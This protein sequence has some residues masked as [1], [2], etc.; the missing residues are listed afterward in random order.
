MIDL[1]CR[2]FP[3]ILISAVAQ[4]PQGPLLKRGSTITLVCNT[5]IKT[6]GSAPQALIQW[7]RR[8]IPKPGPVESQN[9]LPEPADVE[10]PT[11]MAALMYNGVAKIY[12]NSS[13]I[14]I[15]RLS[16]VTYR[17]RIHM[18]TMEDQGVYSCHAEAWG[19]DPHGAWY[20]TGA[21]AE[22]N[23]VTVYLYARG[24]SPPMTGYS[25]GNLQTF[26]MQIVFK[27]VLWVSQ[28]C[29]KQFSI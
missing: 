18:A 23:A 20:S 6:T 28:T 24:K 10:R 8:P 15:D 2:L 29:P 5:T 26:N 7:F 11:L 19:Q 22:S 9:S 17:L 4:I 12:I 3:D 27:T 13:E 21:K 1:I 14:S 16:A 25:N